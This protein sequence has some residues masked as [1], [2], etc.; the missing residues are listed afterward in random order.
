[1]LALGGSPA[2]PD[3]VSSLALALNQVNVACSWALSGGPG[4]FGCLHSTLVLAVSRHGGPGH[5]IRGCVVTPTTRALLC[6]TCAVW[7]GAGMVNP[8]VR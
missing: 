2:A 3:V 6:C 5:S 8:G 1:M 4:G 7:C